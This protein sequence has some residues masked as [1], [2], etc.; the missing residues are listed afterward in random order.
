MVKFNKGQ[1]W[2]TRLKMLRAGKG[3]SQ[4]AVAMAVGTSQRRYCDWENGKRFP[5]TKYQ[6]RLQGFWVNDGKIWE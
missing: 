3:I 4:K 5:R 2:N 6:E 1:T